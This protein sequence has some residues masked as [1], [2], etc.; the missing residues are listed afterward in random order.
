MD[1][2]IVKIQIM[3]FFRKRKIA[4]R[5][6]FWKKRKENHTSYWSRVVELRMNLILLAFFNVFSRSAL[7]S[8]K[9]M[10]LASARWVQ[11]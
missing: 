10:S 8:I 7:S 2:G 1:F 11:F 9:S 6:K 4:Y 5:R 3:I